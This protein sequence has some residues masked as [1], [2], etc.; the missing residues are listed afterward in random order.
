MSTAAAVRAQFV[1]GD[2]DVPDVFCWTKMGTEAGQPLEKI[3]ARKELERLAGNGTFCWGIGNS[4]GAAAS[5]AL[6]KHP[7]GISVLFSPMKS[8]AKKLD[9]NPD[10]VALWTAYQDEFGRLIELP[11]HMVVTSRRHAPSGVVKRSHYALLCSSDRPIDGVSLHGELDASRAVN[12]LSQNSLG[13]SQVTAMVSYRTSKSR[14]MLK[15]Y[16]IRFQAQFYRLG[17]VKLGSPVVLRGKL[18]VVYEQLIASRSKTQWRVTS[19]ELRALATDQATIHRTGSG[20][21]CLL[22]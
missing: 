3:L 11:E 16:P 14:E 13:A 2:R 21:Q 6:A 8:S 15:P 7:E 10:E 20:A 19:R 5:E 9:E 1:D 22:I 18:K 4:L 12:Y 17:F